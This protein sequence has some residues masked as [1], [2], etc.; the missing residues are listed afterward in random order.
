MLRWR[1]EG[2]EL[3]LLGQ[4]GDGLLWRVPSLEDRLLPVSWDGRPIYLSYCAV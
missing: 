1:G 2:V 4:R 3:D